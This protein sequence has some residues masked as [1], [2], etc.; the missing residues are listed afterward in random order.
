MRY[1]I[2]RDNDF[3]K[4]LP[5]ELRLC[6]WNSTR[7]RIASLLLVRRTG[8]SHYTGGDAIIEVLLVPIT[9]SSDCNCHS[10]HL[11]GNLNFQ[12]EVQGRREKEPC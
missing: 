8:G 10:H 2:G 12:V 6:G 5:L 3:S 7:F 9:A 1:L 4:A 11:T